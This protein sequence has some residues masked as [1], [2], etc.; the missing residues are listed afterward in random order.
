ADCRTR[1]R[2]P[3]VCE[4]PCRLAWGGCNDGGWLA[5]HGRYSATSRVSTPQSRSGS[6]WRP[7][8]G[9][10]SDVHRCGQS[11]ELTHRLTP[12]APASRNSFPYNYEQES[13]LQE[14]DPPVSKPTHHQDLTARARAP[15]TIASAMCRQ[16]YLS[17]LLQG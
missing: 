3:F 8:A 17:L 14:S 16:S 10:S 11:H 9:V 13:G 2:S 5:E 12:A 4:S 7:S 6:L 1:R 15:R